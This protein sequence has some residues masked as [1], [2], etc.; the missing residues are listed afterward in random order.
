M[1]FKVGDIVVVKESEREMLEFFISLER[2]DGD[3]KIFNFEDVD[4]KGKI[5]E[6]RN[7]FIIVDFGEKFNGHSGEDISIKGHMFNLGPEDIEIVEVAKPKAKCIESVCFSLSNYGEYMEMAL[8]IACDGKTERLEKRFDVDN[9]LA[10]TVTSEIKE[11]YD[12]TIEVYDKYHDLDWAKIMK[13]LFEI[14]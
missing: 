6:I 8:D 7:E 5:A 9:A 10:Q 14:D 1:E 12:N 13:T 11:L 2:L 4:Y 3:S